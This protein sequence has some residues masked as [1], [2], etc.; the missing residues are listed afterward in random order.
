ADVITAGWVGKLLCLQVLFAVEHG[1]S[2]GRIEQVGLKPRQQNAQRSGGFCG[3]SHRQ[4]VD[5]AELRP[6]LPVQ[7]NRP[8]FHVAKHSLSFP[9][10]SRRTGHAWSR[11]RT[12]DGELIAVP[13]SALARKPARPT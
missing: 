2:A 9:A 11:A 3:V 13:G 1:I 6:K 12:G 8:E 5:A 10:N 7:P 4:S